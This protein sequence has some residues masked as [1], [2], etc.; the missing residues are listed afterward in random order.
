MEQKA[1]SPNKTSPGFVLQKIL[2]DRHRSKRKLVSSCKVFIQTRN[3]SA[4][5][6]ALLVASTFGQG[7]AGSVTINARDTVSLNGGKAFSTVQEGA[8]GS[9]GG[10]DI[11][12]A[13]LFITNGARLSASTFG[14]GDAGSVIINARD[15]VTFDGESGTFSTVQSEA[16]GNSGG[17]NISTRSL[18]M[19]D[20]AEISTFTQ[21]QG[22][23]G[24][25]NI[26]ARSTVSLDGESTVFS[27]VEEEAVGNGGDI[28]I[29]T[30]S[31]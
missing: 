15:T 1:Q 13:S 11:T 2:G 14:Q 31:L 20:R 4:T 19:I 5:N 23:A 7:D 17:I 22:D 21:G 24:S 30:G 27:T 18:S 25:V 6:G 9:S 8:V 26:N 28:N 3:L 12:T 16:I 29:K 10:I